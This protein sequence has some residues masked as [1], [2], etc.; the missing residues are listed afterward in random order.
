MHE[1]ASYI[2]EK[3]NKHL[4]RLW[5][6]KIPYEQKELNLESVLTFLN[7]RY[8]LRYKMRRSIIQICD[9]RK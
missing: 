3:S 9:S 6:I 8:A 7:R 4:V 2:G 5:K 1:I